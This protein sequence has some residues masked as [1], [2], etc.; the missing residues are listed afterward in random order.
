MHSSMH[1]SNRSDIVSLHCL[2]KIFYD[3]CTVKVSK[4]G[5]VMVNK[6]HDICEKQFYRHTYTLQYASVFAIDA[7]DVC[8]T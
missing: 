7:N 6:S 1:G 4:Q 3:M 2:N 8:F 5:S